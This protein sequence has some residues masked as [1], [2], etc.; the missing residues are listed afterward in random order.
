[1][2]KSQIVLEINAPTTPPGDTLYLAGSLNDWKER[3][4]EYAFAQVE[5]GR[6]RLTLQ[7][8]PGSVLE[9]KLNRGNWTSVEVDDSG[10]EQ[11][12]RRLAVFGSTTVKIDVPH[13]RDQASLARGRRLRDTNVRVLGPFPIPALGRDREIAVYLPPN[14]ESEPNR[15][16]PVLYMWDGQNLFDPETAFNQEW[17]VDETCDRLTQ[18]GRI[19]P[20]IV[21]G[22]YNGGEHRLSELSPW[23]D[24]RLGARGEGHAFFRW[25]VGWLKDFIDSE[26]RTLT[27]PEHTGIAG[28]SMGGLAAL[29]VA[30]RYPLVFGRAAA[31]SPAFWFARGQIFRYIAARERP[32]G[33]RIYLDCGERETARVHPKRDFYKVAA[34]MVDLLCQQGF[35]A[36]KDLMWV[37]DP[38]GTHSE[39]DWARRLGPVLEFLFPADPNR[40]REAEDAAR[41]AI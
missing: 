31:M 7:L 28:S 16:F 10:Q 12:N 3:D 2:Q 38:Q 34:S 33:A 8:P 11:E 36:G 20:M 23:R 25:V 19:Q 39:A 22:I 18:E 5:P 17:E 15:R 40:M 14:Y 24:M 29:Y 4:P 9:Y 21:V 6:Y 27:G 26:F 1:M 37:S 32:E 35:K 41:S 30:Y 13:W